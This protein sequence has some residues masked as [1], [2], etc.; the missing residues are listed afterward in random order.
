[1]WPGRLIVQKNTLGTFIP[2]APGTGSVWELLWDS[3]PDIAGQMVY[4]CYEDPTYRV[5]HGVPIDPSIALTNSIDKG[6][7][8]G[9]NYVEIY[10]TDVAHLPAATHYA[11]ITLLTH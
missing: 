4:W 6:V 5:N 8:Y 10:R 7:A 9:M 1:S 2:A 11:H 3:R